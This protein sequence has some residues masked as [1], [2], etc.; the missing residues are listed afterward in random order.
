MDDL[1]SRWEAQLS[2]DLA[3]TTR[4]QYKL[5]ITKIR[6]AFREFSPSDIRPTDVAQ[7][8]DSMRDKPNMANRCRSVLKM[9]MDLAVRHGE[10]ASNPVIS[11]TPHKE[12]KRDRY[13][14]DREYL[15][16]RQQC[17]PSIALVVDMCYLTAQRIDDVLGITLADV[18]N[19][20]IT[21]RQ[22]K[23]GK[24]LMVQMSAAMQD[25][26]DQSKRLGAGNVRSIYLLPGRGGKRRHYTVVRDAWDSACEKA[27]V[28]DAHLHDLRAKSLT[29]ADNQGLNA[30]LLGGHASRQMT[31]RYIRRRKTDVATSPA[32]IAKPS[33]SA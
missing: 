19:E 23:T 6:L 15:A 17:S 16:I 1:A 22:K 3:T 18:S 24:R 11:I 33:K 29:D 27:G 2:D 26:I 14:T 20:G 30:Q 12:K 25:I 8:M 5:A 28:A 10:A 9:M 21:F 31:E 32:M 7:W 13:I 4:N